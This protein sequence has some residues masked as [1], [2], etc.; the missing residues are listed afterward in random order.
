MKKILCLILALVLCVSVFAACD[1]TQTQD[2]EP[3]PL[4]NATA[5]LKTMYKGL[6][7][8]SKTKSDFELVTAVKVNNETYTVE[9]TVD[10]EAVKVV[11]VEGQSKVKIDIDEMSS[12]DVEYNLTAVV[13][14]PDGTKGKP[15]TFKLLVPGL[16]LKSIPDALKLEDDAD[17]NVKGTVV[18]I[19]TPWDDGYKNISVTIEDEEGN[20]LYVYRLSTKVEVG[21]VVIVKGKMATYNNA[22]QVAQGA[23]ADIIGKEEVKTE[24]TEMTIPEVLASDD[25]TLVCVK[26]T[27]KLINTPWSDQYKNITV[28]IVDAQGNELYIYRLATNVE[29]GDVVTIKGVVGSYNGNKQIAQGATAEIGE[30]HGDN[31]VYT[32]DC[33]A[34]CDICG[35]TREG[36]DHDYENACDDECG[37]CGEKRDPEDHVYANDCDVDCDVCGAEREAQGHV[38]DD[39]CDAK[40]N[41]CDAERTAPHKVTAACDTQCDLCGAAITTTTAHTYDFD[42]DKECNVCR[43][44]RA[45]DCKD[46]DD[47]GKCDLCDAVVDQASIELGHINHEAGKLIFAN[48]H[49]TGEATLPATGADYTDVTITWTVEGTAAT[50]A[51]GKVTFTAG[52]ADATVVLKGTFTCGS[53]TEVKEYTVRITAHAYDN[54]CDA[55][56]NKCPAEREVPGHVY[57][58]HLDTECNNCDNGTREAT[59]CVDADENGICDDA[60]CG[61]AVETFPKTNTAYKLYL[62]QQ[63]LNKILYFKGEMGTGSSQYYFATTEDIAEAI[64]LYFEKVDGGYNIYFKTGETKNYLSV[65]N[66]GSHINVKFD[67]GPAVFT[68]DETLNTMVIEVATVGTK[69]GGTMYL[70]TYGTFNTFSAS[71]VDKAPTSFVGSYIVAADAATCT[72]EYAT[73]CAP[74]CHLCGTANANPVHAY[75]NACDAACNVC[76]ATRTVADHN[77]VGG[78]CSICG[79]PDASE[80]EGVVLNANTL[81]LES[82]KYTGTADASA[83]KD[84]NGYTFEFIQI[85]NYGDGLQMRDK[86]G[87][88]TSLWNTTAFDKKIARIELVYSSTKDITHSNADAVIFTFGNS[89]GEA[90]YTTKLSTE[91][92]VKTYTI[93][94]D[95]DTYTFFKLEHDLGYTFYWDSITIYFAE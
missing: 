13:T 9:W 43:T 55:V 95:A 67:Q 25:N 87:K 22:R 48:V 52:A 93:T 44:T 89:A 69:E 12:K 6:L 79:A 26:G 94:P 78:A 16:N 5:Y 38:Y 42:C 63:N 60:R 91:A 29:Q 17:V 28:T 19:N 14:A 30:A 4:E 62:Y 24:Y 32:N 3:T 45:V 56:C 20:Q 47:D 15:L 7:A 11:P 84:V 66:D 86:D 65:V 8:D 41:E 76:K 36:V 72:H 53:T 27:V 50:I 49:A 73:P 68:Y 59:G 81:G 37:K 90:T 51:G 83:T 58:N 34:T 74:K 40:C 23:T 35:A 82:D 88:T 33:D 85:G 1:N 92:G 80:V 57:D 77:Y 64:D 46:E 39:E 2:P 31:H 18:L 54:A 21:D 71:T 70:G 10:N 75:D 61:A